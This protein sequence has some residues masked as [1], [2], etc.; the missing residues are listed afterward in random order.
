MEIL[1][2]HDKCYWIV[3]CNV[4]QNVVAIYCNIIAHM[5]TEYSNISQYA[6]GKSLLFY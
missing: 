2:A 1:Y 5:L 4:P 6:L 3:I